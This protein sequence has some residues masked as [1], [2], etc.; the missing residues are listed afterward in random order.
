MKKKRK[1]NM[2][3]KKKNVLFRLV[4]D[5]DPKLLLERQAM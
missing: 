3:K 4:R 1:G 5:L 2:N